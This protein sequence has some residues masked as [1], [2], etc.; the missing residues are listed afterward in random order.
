MM[1]IFNTIY[2]L[3]ILTLIQLTTGYIIKTQSSSTVNNHRYLIE[4]V[5]FSSISEIDCSKYL[6]DED[7][8]HNLSFTVHINP[9]I[10]NPAMTVAKMDNKYN[11]FSLKITYAEC[12]PSLIFC[13]KHLSTLEIVNTNFCH[14][15]KRI[16]PEIE[17]LASSLTELRISNTKIPHL[18]NEISKLT[19][20][21]TLKLINISLESI[22]DSIGDLLSLK[23]LILNDNNLSTLPET[24]TNLELLQYLTL[25]NNP[26]LRSIKSLN[27][28]PSLGF[29]EMRNCPIELLPHNLPQLTVLHMTNNKLSHLNGIE[30]LGKATNGNKIFDFDGNR[31]LTITPSIDSV[32][33]LYQL[34]LGR[35]ALVVLP[36]NMFNIPTLAHLDIRSNRFP[37]RDL[38]IYISQFSA[39]N[40]NLKLV[41]D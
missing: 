39:T 19:R 32:R 23:I 6:N 7:I 18:P 9:D 29:L 2:L 15:E 5:L 4:S 10:P 33:N 35:N 3:T 24:M 12:V 1:Q 38:Q 27:G 11:V 17:L 41:H 14:F 21:H 16:P 28:H 22:P 13:L 26:N 31:I 25:S 37:A 20:L 34:Q 30:S 36:S 40:S 8:I